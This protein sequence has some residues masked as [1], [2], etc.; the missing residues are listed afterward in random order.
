MLAKQLF[1]WPLWSASFRTLIVAA[2]V[3]ALFGW[4]VPGVNGKTVIAVI[5]NV[6]AGL[7]APHIPV[8]KFWWVK[9]L[10]SSALAV[11]S[12]G[13]LEALAIA[14]SIANQTRQSL[15]F[16][17]QCLAEGLANLTG[18]LIFRR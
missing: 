18:G 10:S 1:C 13:L 12:L 15:D 5:G 9:E 4:S 6:P 8:V 3:A 14:K 11:A 2:V 7:P 16:N 17:Q